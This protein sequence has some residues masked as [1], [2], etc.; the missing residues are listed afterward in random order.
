MATRPRRRQEPKK[1]RVRAV[2]LGDPADHAHVLRQRGEH[3]GEGEGDQRGG[4]GDGA[5][6][7]FDLAAGAGVERLEESALGEFDQGVGVEDAVA[8]LAHALEVPAEFGATGI[9][10]FEA[11]GEGKGGFA[12]GAGVDGGGLGVEGLDAGETAEGPEL[13][14]DVDGDDEDQHGDEDQGELAEEGKALEER[15]EVVV[16]GD[17]DNQRDEEAEDGPEEACAAPGAGGEAHG[18]LHGGALRL[19]V[20]RRRR[21]GGGEGRRGEVLGGDDEGVEPVV[22]LRRSPIRNSA[23][24]SRRMWGRPSPEARRRTGGAKRVRR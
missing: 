16:G 12:V 4:A 24:R 23:A 11:A 21:V 2:G 20:G 10:A 3:I 14:D 17:G 18:G 13:A 5:A 8:L 1:A 9:E 15:G 6:R 19:V 7:G 22:H